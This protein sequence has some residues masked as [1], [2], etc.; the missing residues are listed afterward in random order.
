MTSLASLFGFIVYISISVLGVMCVP[1][2]K[3]D[4]GN[5]L[6]ILGMQSKTNWLLLPDLFYLIVMAFHIPVIFFITKEGIL[7]MVD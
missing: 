6:E 7:I 2:P 3:K 5:I 4:T 1:Y